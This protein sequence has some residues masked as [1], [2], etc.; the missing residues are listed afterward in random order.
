M[1]CKI[2]SH[3]SMV[4]VPAHCMKTGRREAK[5]QGI[6][7]FYFANGYV[8]A[9]LGRWKSKDK[10]GREKSKVTAYRTSHNGRPGWMRIMWVNE[11]HFFVPWNYTIDSEELQSVNQSVKCYVCTFYA[12]CFTDDWQADNKTEK[13]LLFKDIILGF[14]I[15][16]HVPS[17]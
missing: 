11:Y 13:W 3:T 12:K 15:F 16:L 10:L 1:T 6:N 17:L 2:A 14:F 5:K 4:A 8:Y 9:T 7:W